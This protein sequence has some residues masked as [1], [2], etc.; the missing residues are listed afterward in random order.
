[1]REKLREAQHMLEEYRSGK[2]GGTGRRRGADASSRL[3]LDGGEV[4]LKKGFHVNVGKR[5]P[6]AHLHQQA[7]K[8]RVAGNEIPVLSNSPAQAGDLQER[9]ADYEDHLHEV[10][11][12]VSAASQ[13]RLS[14]LLCQISV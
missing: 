11:R 9:V 7:R 10:Q 1:M 14:P 4:R 6:F 8:P 12:Y 13:K 5:W 3:S 2:P